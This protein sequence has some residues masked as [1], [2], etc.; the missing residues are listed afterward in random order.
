MLLRTC[1]KRMFGCAVV[2]SCTSLPNAV[3][4][5]PSVLLCCAGSGA[6]CSPEGFVSSHT[7]LPV[8]HADVLS[9]AGAC[10]VCAWAKRATQN[11]QGLL[12]PS[13]MLEGPWQI[14]SLDF[15]T[16][17]PPS[18]R[19]TAVLVSV[20]SFTRGYFCSTKETACSPS[21]GAVSPLVHRL[22]PG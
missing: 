22:P 3:P 7:E 19:R 15:I 12:Q 4:A 9:C 13:P 2:S 1:G 5:G 16:D 18:W 6:W 17:L 14:I 20:D 8:V 11:P 21:D 10:C